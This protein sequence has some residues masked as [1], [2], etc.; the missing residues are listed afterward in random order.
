MVKSRSFRECIKSGQPD[1][2]RAALHLARELAFPALNLDDCLRQLD[3]LA[4]AAAEH[5]PAPDALP[6][7]AQRA[8]A[9]SAF[10]FDHMGFR[11]NGQH[12][13]SAGNSFLNIV[14]KTRTGI[15]LTLSLLFVAVA[16]RLQ[17]PASGV[18]LP[19]HFIVRVETSGEPIWLDPFNRGRELT[20]A[21]CV[22][23][24]SG[25]GASARTFREAWLEPAAPHEI[26]TRMLN[27]LRLIYLHQKDWPH[28]YKTVRRLML[29]HPA[30]PI[31]F[32]D[33]GVIHF[34]SGRHHLA[35]HA[36][37]EYLRQASGSPDSDKVEHDLRVLL[38]TIAR[39]N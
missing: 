31:F 7:N 8:A 36:L 16:E 22:T 24:A 10:L 23:L 14:L 2:I 1:I 33:L 9:L 11:G 5:V 39:N 17:L 13:Y 26:I 3:A 6:D 25:Y 38:S 35:A 34:H 37:N 18:S 20:H 30:N 21:D 32:R 12:Y 19:G 15:P 27:N 29:L 28:A 4:S